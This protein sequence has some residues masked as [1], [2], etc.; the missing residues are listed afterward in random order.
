[1]NFRATYMGMFSNP[2]E[3]NGDSDRPCS[4][5]VVVPPEAEYTIDVVHAKE[6]VRVHDAWGYLLD[7]GKDMARKHGVQPED[8]ILSS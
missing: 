8:L 4:W 2:Y 5:A 7:A 3:A 1:M 6:M